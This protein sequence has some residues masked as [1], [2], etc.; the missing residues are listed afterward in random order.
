MARASI[1]WPWPL[2]KDSVLAIFDDS[3]HLPEALRSLHT[4]GVA[5]DH[6]WTM[7]GKPGAAMLQATFSQRGALGRI[8]SLLGDEDEIVALLIDRCERGGAAVLVRPSDHRPEDIVEIA[9]PRGARLVRRT[10]R[11]LSQWTVPGV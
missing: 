10:G 4:A 1:L 6:I 7:S 5:A 3:A 8:R 11:W 2:P 9:G